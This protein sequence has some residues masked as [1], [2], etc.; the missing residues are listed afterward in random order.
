MKSRV[1]IY[2]D[3]SYANG[4][5]GLGFFLF[6]VE[7]IRE[8]TVSYG[9]C[10]AEKNKQMEGIA[11]IKALLN[12]EFKSNVEHIE[13]RTDH[14]GIV[15][16]FEE[17]WYEKL[18]NEL[19]GELQTRLLKSALGQWYRLACVVR[20]IDCKISFKLVDKKRKFYKMVDKYA[21]EGLY[22]S[23][24]QANCFMKKSIENE[25]I[26]VKDKDDKEYV[27]APVAWQ[28]TVNSKRWY[29]GQ[30]VI[31]IPVKDIILTENDHLNAKRIDLD[32]IL[33]TYNGCK[34]INIP[35]AVRAIENNRFALITGFTR[36]CIA[37]ILDIET[38]PVVITNLS[39]NEFK[40]K[41]GV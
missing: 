37:K 11:C 4:T 12:I 24:T 7:K 13:I 32:G 30:E 8:F 22:N 10:P 41:Y 21:R 19:C 15:K 25:F 38:I 9:G 36:Y 29:E 1:I 23:K 39:Y 31:Q 26:E 18:D 14:I 5:G 27:Q 33:A 3:G 17:K 2:V 6:F 28:N 20:N 40:L 34:Q 16:F 35:V